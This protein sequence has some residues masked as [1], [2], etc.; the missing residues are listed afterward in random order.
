MA[1]AEEEATCI[2]LWQQ[3]L[4]MTMVTELSTQLCKHVMT[5]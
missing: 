3:G 4:K 2:A 5:D 1:P